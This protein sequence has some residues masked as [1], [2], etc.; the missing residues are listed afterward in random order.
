MPD[1]A[2][3]NSIIPVDSSPTDL[4]GERIEQPAGRSKKARRKAQT[5]QGKGD[6]VRDGFE[7][8]LF[9]GSI[10]QIKEARLPSASSQ[11][12]P[13]V[14][15]ALPQAKNLLDAWAG[16]TITPLTGKQSF[17]DFDPKPQAACSW[18]EFAVKHG[19]EGI[20]RF[21]NL[22]D[23]E[24]V[25][26]L[27]KVQKGEA[28]LEFLERL[29][30]VPAG[31]RSAWLLV[32]PTNA[33]KSYTALEASSLTLKDNDNRQRAIIITPDKDLL[34]QLRR[35]AFQ[36]LHLAPQS[37]AAVSGSTTVKSR[38][39]T[40]ADPAKRL[41]VYTPAAFLNDLE[42]GR[43]NLSEIRQAVL[44]EGHH[45]FDGIPRKPD[46]DFIPP[47]HGQVCKR[48]LEKLRGA[49]TDLVVMTGTPGR[50]KKE[51]DLLRT[52]IEL[53]MARVHRLQVPKHDVSR[54]VLF[55]PLNRFKDPRHDAKL[56]WAAERLL[57]AGRHNYHRMQHYL[58]FGMRGYAKLDDLSRRMESQCVRERS[59]DPQEW[60]EAGYSLVEILEQS[61][62]RPSPL[63]FH[64]PSQGA[65]LSWC[66]E[67]SRME[68]SSAD[69]KTL[70]RVRLEA[71]K[72]EHHRRLHTLLTEN[73]VA[74]Y[75]RN[76][77]RSIFHVKFGV[78]LIPRRDR[79]GRRREGPSPTVVQLF[80]LAHASMHEPDGLSNPI[81]VYRYFACGAPR[82]D[83]NGYPAKRE[84]GSQLDPYK[85]LLYMALLE[86][87][88]LEALRECLYPGEK[89]D[90]DKDF[91]M[92]FLSDAQ[93]EICRMGT[94][95]RDHPKLDSLLEILKTYFRIRP[96]GKVIVR[97]HSVDHGYFLESYLTGILEE[98]CCVS[99]G[100]IFVEGQMPAS[101][102]RGRFEMFHTP[103]A[104]SKQGKVLVAVKLAGEGRHDPEV[105]LV[106]NFQPQWNPRTLK[107]NAGRAGRGYGARRAFGS[108]PLDSMALGHMI[109]LSC[110]LGS[111][112]FIRWRAGEK[113]LQT[114]EAA[115]EG[116]N[117]NS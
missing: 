11:T 21:E 25:S 1:P 70:S 52:A 80:D 78:Q 110:G 8:S 40:W 104:D 44:D 106:I 79:Q 53:P 43:I 108:G 71:W 88:T 68:V 37:F 76:V 99:P 22:W 47:P 92:R 73:G 32:A 105:D 107:Q 16:I 10:D 95:W 9:G 74:T 66:D 36:V 35:D 97:S 69:K 84:D 83:Q 4:F 109:T 30:K 64:F 39:R 93:D 111:Q 48:L 26:D 56:V 81:R 7:V 85:K 14:F 60:P 86:C 41:I 115:L 31:Q 75:L 51:I 15:D 91:A 6:N 13:P 82:L 96:M 24:T 58:R 19:L 61:L 46:P 45:Y 20:L 112:D 87:D 54:E 89:F 103:S 5:R 98:C 57:E 94:Q 67:L 23:R 49:G 34:G 90:S 113:S 17:F 77:A 63:Q 100:V 2:V 29:F 102:R 65:S 27:R 55:H 62:R 50:N 28:Q 12:L 3:P 42:S 33:G 117:W 18:R 116:Y 72:F 101:E 59:P 38:A 114:M